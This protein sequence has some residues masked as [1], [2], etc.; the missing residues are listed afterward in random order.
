MPST[1]AAHWGC[2]RQVVRC[3]N[4]MALTVAEAG[5]EGEDELQHA[6]AV[7]SGWRERFGWSRWLQERQCQ[8]THP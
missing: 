1:A 8:P 4:D 2:Q 6:R 5:G 3:H 7:A